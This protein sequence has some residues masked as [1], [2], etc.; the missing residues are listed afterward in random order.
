M[1]L[2]FCL[3]ITTVFNAHLLITYHDENIETIREDHYSGMHLNEIHHKPSPRLRGGG[4]GW[5][6]YISLNQK[7]LY[8]IF[9]LL[10]KYYSGNF[11]E[12]VQYLEDYYLIFEQN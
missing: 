9:D 2:A 3:F 6:S 5:V 4:W 1:P 10:E 7:P 11:F 12:P 8:Q